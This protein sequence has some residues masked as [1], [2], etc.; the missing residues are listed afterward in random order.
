MELPPGRKAAPLAW[1]TDDPPPPGLWG[2]LR[3]GH[4]STGRWPLILGEIKNAPGYPWTTGELD[5]S[6]VTSRP[7]DHDAD[8]LLA[9]WWSTYTAADDD[10]DMLPSAERRAVT[11]PFD[12]WPGPAPAGSLQEDPDVRA[13][14]FADHLI[15]DNWLTTPRLGLSTSTRGAHAPADLGWGGPL[16]Y[17]NDTAQFSAVLRTWEDRFGV[18]VVGLGPSNLYLSVAAPPVDAGHA[19]HV[20]AEH[21]AFCP[22]NV[23]QSCTTTLVSYAK[24]I[25]GRA[26]WSFWWD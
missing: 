6:L 9:G 18:R 19:L 24:T 7:A 16:N 2:S 17:E 11:A 13:A 8:A 15:T 21:F 23:W 25:T 22:D 4:D 14:E 12:R 5:L 1:L 3:A 20:A 10:D 26:W